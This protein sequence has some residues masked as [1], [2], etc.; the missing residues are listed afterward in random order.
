ME[1]ESTPW[2]T[3]SPPSPSPKPCGS[4]HHQPTPEHNLTPPPVGY[5]VNTPQGLVGSQG[6]AYDYVLARGGVYV[7][8]KGPLILARVLNAPADIRG[9]APTGPKFEL[10]NGLIPAHLFEQILTSFFLNIHFE[11]FAAIRWD[12]NAYQLV[13]PKQTS[14]STS[15]L[16]MPAE[17]TVAEFHSHPN[18]PAFFS[19]T[20][21]RDEQG[22]RAYG[23]VGPLQQDRPTALAL[24][25]GIYGHHGPLS[26]EHLFDGP[27][28]SP[29]QA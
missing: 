4:Q 7:Q 17:N 28:P 6:F 20:D 16:Y 14:T 10:A 27:V 26:W 2:E 1:N 23:V 12:G 21:D 24:R 22:F 11:T 8:A 5:L 13:L 9:L 18:A 25:A 15:L 19:S 3:S 29:A